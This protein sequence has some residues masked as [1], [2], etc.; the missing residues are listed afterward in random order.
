MVKRILLLAAIASALLTGY[1]ASAKAQFPVYG[2]QE[3]HGYFKN[4]QDDWGA[5][6]WNG[7]IPVSVN[8]ATEFI[9][10]VKAKLAFGPGTQNGVGAAFIIQ[11][12][13]GS[14]RNLPPTAGQI[15]N[16]EARVRYAESKGWI[17]WNVLISYQLNSYYQGTAAGSNPVDDAFFNDGVTRVD[18][19]IQFMNGPSIAYELRYA[20]ANPVGTL[21]PLAE[22]IDFDITGRSIVSDAT[23][24]P[25]QTFI[26]EHFLRNNGPDNAP[27]IR[28]A[29]YDLS[30]TRQGSGGPL[31]LGV[32]EYNVFNQNFTVPN[33]ALP[34]TQYC[35]FIQF[36][37]ATDSG[38][39]RNGPWACATVVAQ[40]NLTPSV[41]ASATSAQQNDS[42]TFTYRVNN[43]G[44]T[45]S[46]A[47]ACKVVATNQPPGYVPLP[48]QDVDRNP[49]SGFATGCPRV[50]LNGAT[51]LTTETVSVGNLSPGSKICRSLVVNPKNQSG[52]PRAS[53]ES[54]V[55]IAKT[56]YVHFLGNDVWAGG[57]FA[58]VNPACNTASKIA[59]SSRTLQ[60]G[61]VAGSVVEYGAFALGKITNFGSGSKGLVNPAAPQGKMLT[62]SNIDST[63]L[64]N[65]G[66][67]QHCINDYVAQYQS[68]PALGAGTFDVGSRPNGNWHIT[69]NATFHGTMPLGSQQVYMVTGD[70]TIDNTGIQYPGTYTKFDDIPS[71]VIIATGNINIQSSVTQMDGLYVARG[72]MSTCSNAPPGNLSV[73]TCNAQLTVNGAVIVGNLSLLRTFGADGAT[74]VTRKQPAEVINFNP[75]MYL[76]SAL[77]SSNSTTLRV[78][79]EKD[80]PPRY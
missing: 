32:R 9:N 51:T 40:F 72:T 61:T 69:G 25:G 56:P 66:A 73:S 6:V 13:I 18:R 46:T 78:V 76:R 49:D 80:L 15:A 33:N 23:V 75:E 74:D 30:G 11:T 17:R 20:C 79:D 2:R 70:V 58:V 29:V 21:G 8:T 38:G 44:P 26:F 68:S 42:I 7:G 60:D 1:A 28:Y 5:D 53:A 35:Q 65:Y 27:G 39:T 64:G 36:T 12:M 14:A 43:S 67:P 4:V 55:V 62:F 24:V 16:W 59:T 45:P 48:Q 57:G 19:A 71:L 41:T 22:P 37:P 63:N 54:C 3:F 77:S 34:G 50:F 47:V 31:T 10:F 52:G